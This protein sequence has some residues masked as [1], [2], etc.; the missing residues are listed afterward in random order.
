MRNNQI[1]NVLA[2]IVILICTVVTKKK[3]KISALSLLNYGS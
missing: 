3:S 2:L 1:I